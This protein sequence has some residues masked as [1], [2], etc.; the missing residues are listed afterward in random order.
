MDG[1]DVMMAS[2]VDPGGNE[3]FGRLFLEQP[4]EKTSSPAISSRDAFF[5]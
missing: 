3:S 4:L 1:E 5:Y 2:G